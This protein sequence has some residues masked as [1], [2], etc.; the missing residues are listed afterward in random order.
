MFPLGRR[1][2]WSH[3]CVSH[4]YVYVTCTCTRRSARCGTYMYMYMYMY[5]LVLAQ[6]M[7][8]LERLRH[9]TRGERGE[10]KRI[11]GGHITTQPRRRV[12]SYLRLVN[13][14]PVGQAS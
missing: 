12:A 4:M 10:S 8:H 14:R 5:P 7:K 11:I 6:T 2:A 1:A 9:V 13:L 3:V